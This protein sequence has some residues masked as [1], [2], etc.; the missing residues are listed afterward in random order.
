MSWHLQ[1]VNLSGGITNGPATVSNP[2][3]SVYNGQ[4]HVGYRD[5]A[6]NVWDSFYRPDTNAWNLQKINNGGCTQGPA[7]VAGPFMG[8]FHDQQ[9]F[10]Y[11]D[12]SGNL[13]DSWYDGNGHWNL[14]KINNGGN[15]SGRAA[16]TGGVDLVSIWNDPSG[17]Q[18]HF[19]YLGSDKAVYDTFWDSDNNNWHLQKINDGGN[20]SGP[21]AT[22]SPY[23]CVFH[24]QQHIAYQGSSGDIYDSWYD[25]NGHWNL[26]KINNNGNTSGPAAAPGTHPFVWVDP[27]NTQQH[28]TYLAADLAVYDAF[29]DSDA[30]NWHLQKINNGGNTSGPAATGEPAA[31]CFNQ[32]QHIGY[33]DD[34]GNLWDSWYDGG[35]HWSLQKINNGG[36]TNGGSDTFTPFIWVTGQQQ[37]FTYADKSGAIFDSFWQTDP[38][39][40]G[41]SGGEYT[42]GS[43]GGD[44]D[45]TDPE[46]GDP[47]EEC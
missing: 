16:A 22:S 2:F 17:S 44:P 19:T 14:Q 26:Q 25:G 36:M 9:H 4:Q 34:S 40:T 10:A 28:F 11:L 23:A 46:G 29:W 35:G 27:S 47:T 33:R 21:T 41:G 39:P 42:N 37:H 5:S 12:K 6:G 8:V 18:E 20:T 31:C 32:Q 38:P 24:Q 43:E 1:Q 30:N 3:V 45:P 7:A 15:T 13:W